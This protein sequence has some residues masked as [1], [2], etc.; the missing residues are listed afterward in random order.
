MTPPPPRYVS[1]VFSDHSPDCSIKSLSTQHVDLDDACAQ[2][3]TLLTQ[4]LFHPKGS[5]KML[6]RT[7]CMHVTGLLLGDLNIDTEQIS[8]NGERL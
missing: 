7:Y 8:I 5:R 2:G 4:S 1:V 6:K 3:A